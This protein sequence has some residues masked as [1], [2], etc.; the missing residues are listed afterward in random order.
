VQVVHRLDGDG[1]GSELR[2]TVVTL[3]VGQARTEIPIALQDD[4]LVLAYPKQDH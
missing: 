4:D 1:E 3:L 2:S